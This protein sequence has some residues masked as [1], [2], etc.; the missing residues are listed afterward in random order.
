MTLSC[1]APTKDVSAMTS[2]V[3]CFIGNPFSGPGNQVVVVATVIPQRGLRGDE[4][5]LKVSF[6]VSSLNPEDSITTNDNVAS[7]I[8]KTAAQA[9]ISIDETG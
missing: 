7:V 9:D 4:G 2:S 5:D 6:S 1:G 3:A 8:L